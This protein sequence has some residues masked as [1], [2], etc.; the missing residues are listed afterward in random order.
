MW[1]KIRTTILLSPKQ[2]DG[3]I[4]DHWAMNAEIGIHGPF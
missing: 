1:W 2:T 3:Q 4:N